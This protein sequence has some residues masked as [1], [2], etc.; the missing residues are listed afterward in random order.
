MSDTKVE[1]LLSD[2]RMTNSA[3]Y[4]LV[5]E[6][7][8]VIRAAVP[9]VT[10]KVMYGGLMFA[11]DS[12]FCGVFAYTEHVTVEFGR[13]CDLKD[14]HG[15]LEGSGKFRRHIKLYTTKDIQSKHVREYVAQAEK[16]IH[17]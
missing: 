17:A 4:E 1:N 10:E 2:L 8:K 7:R 3:T 9:K 5:E 16:M 6:L 11:S 15:V 14:T 13:G 12:A